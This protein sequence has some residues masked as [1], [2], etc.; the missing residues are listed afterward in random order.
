MQITY[1]HQTILHLTRHLSK[2]SPESKQKILAFSDMEVS[3]AL[4][5]NLLNT[6]GSKFHPKVNNPFLL[7][8]FCITIAENYLNKNAL[9]WK[10]GENKQYTE[11]EY[12][13]TQ[14]DKNQFGLSKEDSFG[15]GS[16]IEIPAEELPNVKKEIRGKGENVDQLEVNV[17]YGIP[18][19]ETDN[20]VITLG[21]TDQGI[22]LLS[23]YTGILAPPFPGKFNQTPEQEAQSKAFWSKHAF[24]K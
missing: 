18:P 3:E 2:L 9:N 1:S 8:D 7:A 10:D 11:F 14:K 17:L 20:L 12:L 4:L 22:S 5:N 24:L 15:T 16:V 19:Q 21:K 13:V 23:A 6:L